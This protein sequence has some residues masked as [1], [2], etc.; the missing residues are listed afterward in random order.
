MSALIVVCA[1]LVAVAAC[2]DGGG[3]GTVPV[4]GS[5]ASDAGIDVEDEVDA[6][7]G[8]PDAGMCAPDRP[9]RIDCADRV[10]WNVPGQWHAAPDEEGVFFAQ[11]GASIYGAHAARLRVEDRNSGSLVWTPDS[12]ADVRTDSG[13]PPVLRVA[14][15]ANNPNGYGWRGQ[16]PTVSIEDANGG[17]FTLSPAE[18]NDEL[19]PAEGTSWRWLDVPLEERDGWGQELGDTPAAQFDFSAVVRVEVSF[20][21]WGSGFTVD[22]DGLAFTERGV[23]CDYDCPGDCNGRGECLPSELRCRCQQGAVG[24]GCGR[25]GE[26]FERGPDGG[27]ELTE[28][29]DYVEWPNPA[30]DATGD[31]WLRANHQEVE[32]LRPRVLVLNFANDSSMSEVE[33]L[34]DEIVAGFEYASQPAELGSDAEPQLQYEV[35]KVVDMRNGR[36]GNPPVPDGWP[37]DNSTLFPR[38]ETARGLRFDYEE[39]FSRGFAEYYGYESESRDRPARLCELV[40]S[41][42]IHDVWIVG[43]HSEDDAVPAEVL[44]YKQRYTDAGN[45]IPDSF[46]PCAGNG[47]FRREVDPCDRSVRIGFI[48]YKRGPGCYLHNIGHLMEWLNSHHVVPEYSRWFDRFA[49]M[50]LNERYDLPFESLYG[51]ECSRDQCITYPDASTIEIRHLGETYEIEDWDPVCGNCHFPPNA[52]GHYDYGHSAPVRTTCSGFGKQEVSCRQ[53]AASE[54]SNG[55]WEELKSDVPDCG[56]GFLVWWYRRMPAHGTSHRYPS[57]EPMKSVWPFLFY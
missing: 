23:T 24:A 4:V 38:E 17:S 1:V 34:V 2:G 9:R 18:G 30:S 27:C 57:G 50:D 15:R 29:G 25:C 32:V 47:C 45:P 52:T 43:A 49:G 3:D 54:V 55:A 11:S 44:E 48:N 6:D 36:A 10:E 12:P 35:A 51:V 40:E 14:V 56:G 19:L 5:D 28:D 39:M 7:G 41:G 31:A 13:D 42:R 8:A 22:L 16:T 46:S 26:G 21:T 53:D 33:Q 37:H 20:R